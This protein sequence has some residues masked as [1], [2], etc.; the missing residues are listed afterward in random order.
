[1]YEDPSLQKRYNEDTVNLY[2]ERP[3][4]SPYARASINFNVPADFGPSLLDHKIF[5]GFTANVLL[6]WSDGG[7][8]TWNPKN[9]PRISYNVR[10]KD[11]FNATLRLMK[12]IEIKRFRFEFLMDISNLL[13]TRRLW[14]T[15]DQ[16]YRT[17]L[18]LPAS[19]D[20]DNIVGNDKIG[21]Y[22]EP[23]VEFQPMERRAEIN[24]ETDTGKTRIIYYELATGD[25]LQYVD[26][27]WVHVDKTRMDRILKD[28]AYIDMPN[29]STFWFL[30][31]RDIYFGLR[32]TF[33]LDKNR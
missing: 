23:G 19:E 21:D 27:S 33:D 24:R 13:N 18:H 12:A 5:G 6:N 9:D 28:K 11:Y 20:Y 31:P 30:N 25:Y 17:S 32:I 16:D 10:V 3:I 29:A 22:R 15:G 8:S 1:M 7:Y 26:N 14:N 2:Q 4:P